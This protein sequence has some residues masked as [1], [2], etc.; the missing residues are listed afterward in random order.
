MVEFVQRTKF[1]FSIFDREIIP[2]FRIEAR[3]LF[4]NYS[5]FTFSN[6]FRP[7]ARGVLS[8]F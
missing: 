6:G 4:F 1:D 3:T 8:E 5:K 2:N 7:A